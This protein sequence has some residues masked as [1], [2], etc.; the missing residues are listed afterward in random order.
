MLTLEAITAAGRGGY[1]LIDI[2]PARA[3]ELMAE[4]TPGVVTE[5]L[6]ATPAAAPT[7]VGAGSRTSPG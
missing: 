4:T 5:L 2:A 6:D 3:A 7:G 1:E